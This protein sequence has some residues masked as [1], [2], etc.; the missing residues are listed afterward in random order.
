M[1]DTTACLIA[2]RA[3]EA[4][5]GIPYRAFVQNDI[6]LWDVGDVIRRMLQTFEIRKTRSH[7]WHPWE[8]ST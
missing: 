8:L 5:W 3:P 2:F 7:P 4:A 6:G 1:W